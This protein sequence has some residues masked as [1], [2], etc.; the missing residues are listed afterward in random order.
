MVTAKLTALG[1]PAELQVIEVTRLSLNAGAPDKP[2]KINPGDMI[3]R[4]I[5][6]IKSGNCQ[7]LS[8]ES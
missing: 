7:K 4:K 5:S 1:E 6:S 3:R 8:Q 2:S